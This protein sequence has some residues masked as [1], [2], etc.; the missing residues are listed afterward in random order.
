MFRTILTAIVAL[1]LTTGGV[2]ADPPGHA[3]NR[4]GHPGRGWGVG[5]IPPGHAKKMYIRGDYLPKDGSWIVIRDPDRYG[6]PRIRRDEMYV[7]I[8]DQVVRAA[9]DTATVIAAMGIV[10]DWLN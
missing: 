9:R 2:L 10:S 4:D 7:R 5:G 1:T 3:K 6:L 8:D